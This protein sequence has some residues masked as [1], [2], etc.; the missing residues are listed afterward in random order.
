M[1]YE[2]NS[3]QHY[4]IKGQSWGVRRFQNEDGSLTE[5]GKQ[6]YGYY[7]R[8][9]GTK[10]YKRIKKDAANDAKEYARAKAYYGEGA[11]TRRKK[12]KNR[13]SERMKDPDYKAEFD[14]QMKNQDMEKHQKAADRERKVE[15]TKQFVGK[16]ARGVKNF[17]LGVGTASLTAISLVNIARATG[18][19]KKIAEWGKTTLSK[20]VDLFKKRDPAVDAYNNSR[21]P[22][23]PNLGG[24]SAFVDFMN[25]RR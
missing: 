2:D 23:N 5:A 8:G 19:D 10:D 17:L 15:D 12:I 9:D 11:G 6:R 22:Y 20:V 18:A 3:L 16:T 14:R 21:T 4:G 7:D 13:I 25:R 1:K 24:G